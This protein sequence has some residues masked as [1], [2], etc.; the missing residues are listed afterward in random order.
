MGRRHG[1][2][3]LKSAAPRS[4]VAGRAESNPESCKNPEVTYARSLTVRVWSQEHAHKNMNPGRA[5]LQYEAALCITINRK[6][7]EHRP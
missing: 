3:L 5:G 7:E 4:E 1:R 6:A 2:Q